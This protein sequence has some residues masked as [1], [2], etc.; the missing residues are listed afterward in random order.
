TF[1]ATDALLETDA[2]GTH[3]SSLPALACDG[4]DVY[5]AWLDGRSGTPAVRMNRSSDGGASF[6]GADVVVSHPATPIVDPSG[7]VVV[8]R[9]ATVVAAWADRRNGAASDV[10]LNRSTDGGITFFPLDRRLDTDAP[11]AHGSFQPA[12]A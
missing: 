4:S 6:L 11:G 12:L 3:D 7:P 10:F 1:P 5:A 2:A 9:G 8:C